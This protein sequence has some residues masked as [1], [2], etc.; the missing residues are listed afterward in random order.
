MPLAPLPASFAGYSGSGELHCLVHAERLAM[1]TA[2]PKTMPCSCASKKQV[3]Y[4]LLSLGFFADCYRRD[5]QSASH[6]GRRT[7]PPACCIL[8]S[9]LARG[10]RPSA[11][12]TVTCCKSQVPFPQLSGQT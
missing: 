8:L 6:A 7:L 10:R 9:P 4:V 1:R 2:F 5:V 3:L 11:R 12:S